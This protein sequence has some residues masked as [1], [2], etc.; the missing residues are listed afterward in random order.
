M[1]RGLSRNLIDLYIMEILIETVKIA[2]DV[3]RTKMVQYIKVNSSE[4]LNMAKV[5]L[6]TVMNT[7]TKE[8][9]FSI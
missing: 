9:S 1:V 6:F 8:I 7:S 3:F 2:R 5:K 4:I